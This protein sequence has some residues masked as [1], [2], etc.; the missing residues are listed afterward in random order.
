MK[1]F[2]EQMDINISG[3]LL[4]AFGKDAKS[5]VILN[6]STK[7]E[8]DDGVVMEAVVE[9]FCRYFKSILHHN[10]VDGNEILC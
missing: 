4:E 3:G 6:N 7:L 1:N 9:K 5:A 8:G 2:I 10:Q